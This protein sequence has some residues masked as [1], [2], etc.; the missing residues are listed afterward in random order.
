MLLRDD[1][2]KTNCNVYHLWE[3]NQRPLASKLEKDE[4]ILAEKGMV[5]LRQIVTAPNA[6]TPNTIT[7]K[8]VTPNTNFE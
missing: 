1:I 3:H 8:V 6:I 7:P 2:S 4:N 5:F